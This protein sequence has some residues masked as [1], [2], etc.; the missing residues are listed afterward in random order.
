MSEPLM[1]RSFLAV[2]ILLLVGALSAADR[3]SYFMRR[4][5][6]NWSET[7]GTGRRGRWCMSRADLDRLLNAL[8][9]FAQE[10]LKK[11][12]EF[13]PFAMALTSEGELIAV[14]TYTGGENPPSQ[15]V[16][17]E[18]I[19]ALRADA[20][21]GRYRA[22]GICFDVRVLPPNGTEKS[23]AV[24]VVLEHE[25]GEAVQVF[26]PYGK[27]LFGRIAY[28]DLFATAATSRIFAAR[29]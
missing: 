29:A 15:Q 28:G 21:Q 3:Y 26:L 5:S 25:K 12:G 4:Y 16:I 19:T 20:Q 6:S 17:D 22:T 9:P 10:M 1:R 18:L 8:L 2:G 13:Y 7:S 24:A 27:K 14:T 11:H 23:D